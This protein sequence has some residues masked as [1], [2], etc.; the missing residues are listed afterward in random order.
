MSSSGLFSI[1]AS[2]GQSDDDE[3]YDSSQNQRLVKKCNLLITKLFF[4]IVHFKF[5]LKCFFYAFIGIVYLLCK[6]YNFIYH[7]ILI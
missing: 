7:F 2:P 3:D 4:K 1:F 5:S 6:K